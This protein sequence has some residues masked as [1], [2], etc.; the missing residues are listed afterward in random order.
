MILF[1]DQLKQNLREQLIRLCTF[2]DASCSEQL[3][4]CIVA[5]KKGVD[6][7]RR[8]NDSEIFSDQHRRSANLYQKE[9]LRT[10]KEFMMDEDLVDFKKLA[11]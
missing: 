8:H 4:D 10:V 9:V 11:L 1:Y 3:L 6:N 7:R 2:F 5:H